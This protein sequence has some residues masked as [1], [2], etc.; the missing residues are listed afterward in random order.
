MKISNSQIQH[1][2]VYEDE[3]IERL[4]EVMTRVVTPRLGSGY[5][6]VVSRDGRVSGVVTDADFRK[7]SARTGKLPTKILEVVHAEFIS[8]DEGLTEEQVVNSLLE[9]MD[10]RG[11]KTVL[12]VRF[13]PILKSGFPVGVIDA[14]DLQIEI[15]SH[16]DQ[17]VVVGLGYVGLTLVELLLRRFAT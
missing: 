17:L 11:W 1:L 4:L 13:V 2:T 7:Y 15:S 8:V 14:Q 6:I 9:Q 5:A 12:P 10:S 16:R 3:P